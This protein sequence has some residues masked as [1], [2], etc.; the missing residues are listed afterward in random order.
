MTAEGFPGCVGFIDG[1][2]L[3]LSQRS[4]VDESSYRDQKRYSVS[5]QAVCDCDKL[6]IATAFQPLRISTTRPIHC[7]YRLSATTPPE[8]QAQVETWPVAYLS[9]LKDTVKGTKYQV[10]WR[11]PYG[12]KGTE[13][14]DPTWDPKESLKEDIIGYAMLMVNMWVMAGRPDDFLQW[15]RRTVPTLIDANAS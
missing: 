12:Y 11:K 7:R 15:A 5:M 13:S 4:A 3:P 8:E 6:I 14:W 1:T 10:V 2:A 9:D